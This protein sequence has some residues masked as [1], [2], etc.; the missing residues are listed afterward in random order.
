MY[1]TPTRVVAM[2]SSAMGPLGSSKMEDH[3]RGEAEVVLSP[4]KGIGV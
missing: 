4:P 1:K 2:S 3:T